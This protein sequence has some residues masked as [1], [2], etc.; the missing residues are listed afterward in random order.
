MGDLDLLGDEEETTEETSEESEGGK[1]AAVDVEAAVTQAVESRMNA[2]LSE[3]QNGFG[4]LQQRIAAVEQARTQVTQEIEEDGTAFERFAKD[5]NGVLAKVVQEVLESQFS[6]ILRA[7]TEGTHQMLVK[8][9]IAELE[10]THGAG[11]YNEIKPIVEAGIRALSPQMRTD[12]KV[13]ETIFKASLGQD[14]VRQ[15]MAER[16]AKVAKEG[17]DPARL[18]PNGAAVESRRPQLTESD[19]RYLENTRGDRKVMEAIAAANDKLG[20]PIRTLEEY[21]AATKGLKKG[22]K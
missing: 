14:A 12:P 2:L 10:T 15:K 18:L 1:T 4:T 3:V 17:R 6:P 7:S 19:L 21:R 16:E 20:R 9:A 22:A 11:A 8:D 5:P 13:I